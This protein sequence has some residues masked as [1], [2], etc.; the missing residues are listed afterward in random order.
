M[1]SAMGAIQLPNA[2][3]ANAVKLRGDYSRAS[4]DYVVEQ[5]WL[6]YTPEQHALWSTLMNRQ[7]ELVKALRR[8]AVPGGLERAEYAGGYSALRRG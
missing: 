3:A 5:D 1:M 2:P 4:A 7:L 6:S 8:P